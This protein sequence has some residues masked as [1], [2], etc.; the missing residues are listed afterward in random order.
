MQRSDH[1]TAEGEQGASR[2]LCGDLHG[3]ESKPDMCAELLD[4]QGQ[5]VRRLHFIA[6]LF[7]IAI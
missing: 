4:P 5:I 6:G 3:V 2:S 1:G 7:Q